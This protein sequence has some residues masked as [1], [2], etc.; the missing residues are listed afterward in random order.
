MV[1]IDLLIFF[2]SYPKGNKRYAIEDKK[3]K[4]ISPL[5]YIILLFYNP[6]Y[7]PFI[8]NLLKRKN[9]FYNEFILIFYIFVIV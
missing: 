3:Y 1:I 8:I 7:S 5:N 4:N 2:Q 9:E 6:S